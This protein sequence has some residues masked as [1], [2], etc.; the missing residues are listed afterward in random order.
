MSKKKKRKKHHQ[1]KNVQNAKKPEANLLQQWLDEINK[2]KPIAEK[3]Q[4]ALEA[5]RERETQRERE[6]EN[7]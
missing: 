1:K 6:A 2:L 3:V 4:R 7:K 5:Q